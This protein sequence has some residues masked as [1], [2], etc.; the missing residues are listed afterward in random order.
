MMKVKRDRDR[1]CAI[2]RKKK[3]KKSALGLK[4]CVVNE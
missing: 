4:I 2:V 1:M 3:K